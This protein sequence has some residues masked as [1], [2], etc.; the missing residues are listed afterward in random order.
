MVLLV[1]Y[2]AL[3]KDLKRLP[4]M[5]E[6]RPQIFGSPDRTDLD[7]LSAGDSVYS[8]ENLLEILGTP[9]IDGWVLVMIVDETSMTCH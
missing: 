5:E 7:L 8:R 3:L 4:L 9:V 1:G 2:R 6:I